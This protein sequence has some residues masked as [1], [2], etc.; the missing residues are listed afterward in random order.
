VWASDSVDAT[1]TL[2]KPHR[3]PWKVKVNDLASLL[4]VHALGQHISRH[5]DVV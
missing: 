4:Q 2:H 5:E 1:V 3:I